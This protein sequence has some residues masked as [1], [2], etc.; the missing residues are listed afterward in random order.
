VGFA[1]RLLLAWGGGWVN[2][3]R[4]LP[5]QPGRG[6]RGQLAAFAAGNI[7]ISQFPAK[8]PYLT[9]PL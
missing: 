5:G 9:V 6:D 4:Y 7:D 1:I 2:L 8:N 3:G